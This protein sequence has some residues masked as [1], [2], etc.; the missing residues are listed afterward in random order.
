MSGRGINDI[1][2]FRAGPIDTSDHP[3]E[4]WERWFNATFFTMV[5]TPKPLI[6]LDELRRGMEE[7]GEDAYKRLA[8][9]ERQLQSFANLLVEKGLLSQDEIDRRAAEIAKRGI[10]ADRK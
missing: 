3:P 6:R 5:T 10:S 7:L 9:F 1:G 8:Y 2:G 4:Q